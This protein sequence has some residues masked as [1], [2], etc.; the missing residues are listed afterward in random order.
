MKEFFKNQLETL[1]TRTGFRQLE[2]M[3][4][5]QGK[6]EAGEDLWKQ[7]VRQLINFM[8][9]ECNKPPF[10]NV[11]ETVKARVIARAVVEDQEFTGL[12]AK[13]VRRALN[14]WWKDNGD[15]VLDA[16]NHQS[17]GMKPEPLTPE[18]NEKINVLLESYRKSLLSPMPQMKPEEI[19]KEGA[20]WKSEL[21]RKAVSKGYKPAMNREDIKARELHLQWI[22]ENHNPNNGF[23]LPGWI[24]EE[25]W[26]K[27]LKQDE[28]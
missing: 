18:Q 14:A 8:V 23:K 10:D 1:Y 27:K 16:M 20:E 19:E 13:F 17:A 6:D 11:K 7:D 21:E 15:R 24:S 25:E 5:R 2:N 4:Q 22:R 3:M 26:L 12:N 9:E 28:K